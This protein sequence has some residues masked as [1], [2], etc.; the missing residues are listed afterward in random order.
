MAGR[1][2][3]RAVAVIRKIYWVLIPLTIGLMA[4]HNAGDWI[5]KLRRR[6]RGLPPPR[7]EYPGELRMF[8]LERVQ[9]GL[10]MASFL[11]LAWTGFALKY[12][13]ALW[14][15]PLVAWEASWSVRGT[16]HRVAAGIFLATAALHLLSL[17]FSRPL[18]WH[19][20]SLV[21]N[22][23]DLREAAAGFAFNL[24]LR[25]EQ[26]QLSAHSYIEKAEYWAVVWGAVIMSITGVILWANTFFLAW[27]PK[28]VM[29]AATAI[30]FYE[31]ILAALAILVWH[32]YFVIFDPDVYPLDAAWLRGFSLRKRAEKTEAE[33]PEHA[34]VDCS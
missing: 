24:G 8:G 19:W 30:H 3:V 13:E 7:L 29:D 25:K 27:L 5:R 2:E 28:T 1:A 11:V 21:P 14:A 6:W 15:R 33:K 26:P 18:R 16:I 20:L 4:L 10:L 32:F 23:R 17:I 31:A 9:H 22:R 12:P 34:T